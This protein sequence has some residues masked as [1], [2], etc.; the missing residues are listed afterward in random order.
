MSNN[1]SPNGNQVVAAPATNVR[2]D[3]PTSPSAGPIKDTIRKGQEAWQRL[4]HNQT[5]QDWCAVGRAHV[6]GRTA[7]MQDAGCNT[8]QGHRYKTAFTAWQHKQ[9]FENLDKGDRCRLFE[10]MDNLTEIE[11]WRLTLTPRARAGLNHPSTVLRRWKAAKRAAQNE[12]QPDLPNKPEQKPPTLNPLSWEPASP[13]ER[14][15]FIS[16]VG[17]QTISEV[18][19]ED[20]RP[21]IEEWLHPKPTAVVIDPNGYPIP[22]DLSIPVFLK[23]VSP[24]GVTAY[25]R[26]RAS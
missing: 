8:P 13:A 15:R 6:I 11:A 23:V 9:G 17:W 20:W 3:N 25:A 2:L 14:P 16:A 10:V 18:I 4:Q 24:D 26:R 7:A 1:A 5:Y 19:P 21:I 12:H 22:E